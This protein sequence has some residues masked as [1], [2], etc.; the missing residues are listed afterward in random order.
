MALMRNMLIS[1]HKMVEYKPIFLKT[2]ALTR[3]AFWE[4]I[5]GA[6]RNSDAN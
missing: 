2:V 4:F 5:S 3:S 1:Y 6:S